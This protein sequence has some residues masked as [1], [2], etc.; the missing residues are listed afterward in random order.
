MR[1]TLEVLSM[2]NLALKFAILKEYPSQSACARDI[3]LSE[4][5]LSKFVRGWRE[6]NADQKKELS[7]K[8][9]VKVHEIF[10]D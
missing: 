7:R 3:G 1:A 6:P 4:S 2:T 5:L 8:L 10:P 9:K